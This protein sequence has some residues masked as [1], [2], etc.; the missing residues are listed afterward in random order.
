MDNKHFDLKRN[1][2]ASNL[3]PTTIDSLY[4]SINNRNKHS[5]SNGSSKM[6]LTPYQKLLYNNRREKQFWNSQKK[7]NNTDNKLSK[8]PFT[9]EHFSFFNPKISKNVLTK[10]MLSFFKMKTYFNQFS[11]KKS[12]DV[13][14]ISM[15]KYDSNNRNDI[16]QRRRKNKSLTEINRD[17][18]V[19]NQTIL[20][21]K[22]L[23]KKPN[24]KNEG[25]MCRS[26][27]QKVT[28]KRLYCRYK[29]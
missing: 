25:I 1:Q 26:T 8:E 17:R 23:Q 14:S 3:H 11:N 20:D 2:S 7:M 24:T 6:K 4:Y 5:S 27:L 10:Q 21:I 19:N 22:S 28:I 15:N 18:F 29:L 12:F 16:I 9:N 13:K